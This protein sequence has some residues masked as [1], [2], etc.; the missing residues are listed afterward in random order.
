MISVIITT[1]NY[2]KYI[3]R[4]IRSVLEQ[5][6][7]R[8]GFEVIVVN[9]ASTDFTRKILNNYRDDV[10]V[11]DLK[12]NVGL[13]AARN[14]GVEKSKGQFVVFLDA[15]DFMHP[16][17]LYI[18][19]TFLGMNAHI[20]AVAVDYM[21]TDELGTQLVER[22]SAAQKPIAC[23]I[24]FR[25]DLFYDIG[26][27]DEKFRAREEEDFRIRFLKKYSIY[28]I[29]LPLYRYRRHGGNLT[30]NKTVMKKYAK[31]L[32]VKHAKKPK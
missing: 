9:D 30:N 19:S 5:S 18:Q 22:V 11:I 26:L 24:M 20:D 25:K 31:K 7:P 8:K 28:N 23:G 3:E 10:R 12:K 32:E 27:Y 6:L 2:Q 16:D 14:V 1:H 17:M 21:L 4:A 15:D 13:A 29:P